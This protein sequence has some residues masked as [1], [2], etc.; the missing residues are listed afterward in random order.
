MRTKVALLAGLVVGVMVLSAGLMTQEAKAA[1]HENFAISVYHGING[2]SLGLSKELPVVATVSATLP[3]GGTLT[4]PISL[5][6]KDRV[7]TSL[8]EGQY[9]ITVA[10][11]E[12]GPLPSMTVGPVFIPAGVNVYL[13]A[14]LSGGKTP[15]LSVRVR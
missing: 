14:R 4:A 8:P 10:S 2:R 11:A 12:A 5:E 3:G 9:T 6:F 7:S 15:I 13:H 1:G